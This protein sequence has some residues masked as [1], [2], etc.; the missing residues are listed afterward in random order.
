MEVR[1]HNFI[2]FSFE[3]NLMGVSKY[4]II[5]YVCVCVFLCAFFQFCDN[6]QSGDHP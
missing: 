6:A 5:K 3:K 1:S 2:L 4:L